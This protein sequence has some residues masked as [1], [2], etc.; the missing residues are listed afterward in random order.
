MSSSQPRTSTREFP[1]GAVLSVVGGK[2]LCEMGEIYEIMGFLLGQ[3]VWTHQLVTYHDI[4]KAEIVAQHPQLKDYEDSACNRENFRE[5][6]ETQTV[7]YGDILPIQPIAKVPQLDPVKDLLDMV[8][9][10]K[11]IVIKR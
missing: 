3:P 2:L 4:C 7:K 8:P 11:V 1:I 10:E 5:F 9:A 6:L